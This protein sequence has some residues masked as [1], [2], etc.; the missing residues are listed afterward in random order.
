MRD[1]HFNAVFAIIMSENDDR[2]VLCVCLIGSAMCSSTFAA[3]HFM[4]MIYH[5]ITKL[6][7]LVIYGSGLVHTETYWFIYFCYEC[8]WIC[9]LNEWLPRC[10]A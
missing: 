3:M 2:H 4:I 6:S 8:I 7:I 9:Y 1:Q 5:L 10:K